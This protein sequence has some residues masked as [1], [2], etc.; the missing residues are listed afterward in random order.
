MIISLAIDTF[1]EIVSR[2]N[3][4]KL[5]CTDQNMDWPDLDCADGIVTLTF[6]D[7]RLAALFKLTW[8]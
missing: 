2:Y 6:P 1:V 8:L 3:E 7:E 4:I 5:W